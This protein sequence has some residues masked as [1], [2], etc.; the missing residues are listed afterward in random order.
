MTRLFPFD[1]PPPTAFYLC[2]YLLTLTIHVVFMNYV[3]AGTA[4][5]AFAARH[6]AGR[7]D[8]I[9]DTLRDW[10][11]FATSA[12]I[13]AGVAPL[14]FLQILYKKEFYTAN[15]LLFNRWMI[16]VPV[17][18][19]GFYMLYLVK[20]PRLQQARRTTQLLVALGAFAAFGFTGFSWTE[21][22]LLST[23]AAAWPRL[24]E[25]DSI[26]YRNRELIPRL[27]VW[28][29]GAF[30]TMCLLVGWQIR[31][32]EVRSGAPRPSAAARLAKLSVATELLAVA[33][34]AFYCLSLDR[35]LF[36]RTWAPAFRPYTMVA[37]AGIILQITAWCGIWGA[38][39]LG[40]GLGRAWLA[41]GSVG[42]GLTLLGATVTRE[43]LR[44]ARIDISQLY[45]QHAD[46]LGMGGLP[47]FLIFFT[48]NGVLI[49]VCLRLCLPAA[50]RS[51]S[52]SPPIGR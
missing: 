28:F 32:Q 51:Q 40:S 46:A 50:S 24:Y 10:L 16:I 31:H 27:G 21:N 2:A 3:L 13:T 9:G 15:L 20:A 6:V 30:P 33:V 44:L 42:L 39:S 5:L 26:L 34:A 25:S 8:P 52:N 19:I 35:A 36:D 22:H 37:I 11:P 45:N 18:I 12:A 43:S 17:L 38:S 23:D 1:L 4:Y 47:A 48:I 7:N 14:L 29:I 41:I 49:A